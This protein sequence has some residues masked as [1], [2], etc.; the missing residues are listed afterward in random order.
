MS[1]NQISII[2]SSRYEDEM[3]LSAFQNY[4]AKHAE[5]HILTG[6]KSE[7]KNSNPNYN[8]IKLTG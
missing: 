1:L 2:P 6:M 5:L 3:L 8:K 7:E 4:R